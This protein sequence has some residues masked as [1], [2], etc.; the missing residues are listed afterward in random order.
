MRRIGLTGGIASGK[1]LVAARLAELGA[2][3]VDADVLARR[4]VEPGT[5]GLAAIRETFGDAV[6][7]ADGSLDRPALGALVFADPAARERLN[8]IVHPLVRQAS[9]ELIEAA[10]QDAVVVE[11]IPLLVETG[12]QD[13]FD[14][15]LVVDAA[16]DT[17]VRRMMEHRAMTEQDARARI[18]AQATRAERNAAATVVIPNEGT[19]E[20]LLQR[21]DQVWQELTGQPDA[22]G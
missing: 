2:V 3:L 21:V 13:R 10:P 11:D 5:S 15:V 1:S 14:A 18:A 12:Q 7:S 16:D 6:I 19:R 9:A 20:E 17:R 22:D 4:V 8:A